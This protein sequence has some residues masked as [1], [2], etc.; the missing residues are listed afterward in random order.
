MPWVVLDMLLPWLVFGVLLPWA[1]LVGQAQRQASWRSCGCGRCVWRLRL[2]L[3]A[4]S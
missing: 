1:V 4:W 3:W 2:P